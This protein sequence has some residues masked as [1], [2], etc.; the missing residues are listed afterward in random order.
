MFTG[1]IMATVRGISKGVRIG[2]SRLDLRSIWQGLMTAFGKLVSPPGI[3]VPV[4][5]RKPNRG[6]R[7]STN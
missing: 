1:S 4:R 3:P 2:L 6:S 7:R 5:S